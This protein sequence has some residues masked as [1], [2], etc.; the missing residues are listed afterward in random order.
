VVLVLVVAMENNQMDL[1]QLVYLVQQEQLELVVLVL[2]VAMEN[3][4]MDLKQIVYLVQQEQLELVVLVLV[5]IRI[6]IHHLLVLLHVLYVVVVD[7]E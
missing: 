4:Q 3:N 1:K 2:V 5:V 6:L 7:T